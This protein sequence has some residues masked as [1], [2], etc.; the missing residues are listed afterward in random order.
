[1]FAALCI[2]IFMHKSLT[3]RGLQLG[4]LYHHAIRLSTLSEPFALRSACSA[5][6][7]RIDDGRF[8]SQPMA[9]AKACYARVCLIA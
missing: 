7:L 6:H 4:V 3:N 9:F 5:V 2:I 8:L 1:M